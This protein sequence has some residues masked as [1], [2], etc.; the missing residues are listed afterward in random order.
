MPILWTKTPFEAGVKA[1]N[2]LIYKQ[3]INKFES[4]SLRKQ[5]IADWLSIVCHNT[6]SMWMALPG[7]VTPSIIKRRGV[8]GW[9]LS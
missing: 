3:V 2:R 1:G 5:W 4:R 6:F 9:S 8:V 7:K